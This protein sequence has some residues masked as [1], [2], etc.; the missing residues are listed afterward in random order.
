MQREILV[1]FILQVFNLQEEMRLHDQMIKKDL[2][3]FYV[4]DQL[5]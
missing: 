2:S 4:I 1:F 3:I 5:E